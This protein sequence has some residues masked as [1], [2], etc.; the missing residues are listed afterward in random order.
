MWRQR[1]KRASSANEHGNIRKRIQV[2]VRSLRSQEFV[3][4]RRGAELRAWYFPINLDFALPLC[5]AICICTNE[6]CRGRTVSSGTAKER[7]I[8]YEWKLYLHH[9]C[10]SYVCTCTKTGGSECCG[11]V[12]KGQTICRVYIWPEKVPSTSRLLNGKPNLAAPM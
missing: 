9:W 6:G 3:N 1:L 5:S 7:I 11:T 8:S 2:S 12:D 10:V 4:H